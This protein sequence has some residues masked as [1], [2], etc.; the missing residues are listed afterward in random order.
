M[1]RAVH[2]GEKYGATLSLSSKTIHKYESINKEN[3]QGWYFSDGFIF[4]YPF[5]NDYDYDGHYFC[6]ASPYL[7]A[8]ATV[9]TAERIAKNISPSMPNA[10][11]YAGG[12]EC[13]KY[14]SAGFILGYNSIAFERG[15]HKDKKDITIEAKF[16]VAEFTLTTIVENI[17]TEVIY[18]FGQE[19][20]APK[21][22][23]REGYTFKG[24][25]VEIPETM[26]AKDIVAEAVW[27]VNQ[28]NL[29]VIVDEDTTTTSY[30]YNSI[31]EKPATPEKE[32]YVFVGWNAEIPYTMPAEDVII[33]AEFATAEF[34]F[35]TI[36][37]N[38]ITK[39]T[40]NFGDAVKTPE[41]PTREGYTFEG[42][43]IEIPETMPAKDIVA[44]AEWKVNQY[45]V[46]F[47]ADKDTVQEA[48]YSTDKQISR[49]GRVL[50]GSNSHSNTSTLKTS[51]S[52]QILF[53]FH[54][55]L[56]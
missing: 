1:A 13:G 3:E 4:M 56:Y 30:N 21:K 12:V 5:D 38:V 47:I 18:N 29:V 34:T 2:H 6:H 52:M 22:P 27:E 10:S 23:T 11:N 40:Y 28:Y 25:S 48:Y 35:T 42:W 45:T 49:L 16:V 39:E 15:T 36:V 19:I 8:G 43:S 33:E 32:G 41:E 20:N 26:P 24:W 14:G 37:E 54:K 44:E 50:L 51:Y 17:K 46:T 55:Y 53:T 31:I 9:N 7:R